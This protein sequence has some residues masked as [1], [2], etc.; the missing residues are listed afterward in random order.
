MSWYE[1]VGVVFV[2]ILVWVAC[3][4]AV[5]RYSQ[6]NQWGTADENLGTF[7]CTAIGPVVLPVLGVIALIRLAW[8]L[9]KAP[10][11]DP[12]VKSRW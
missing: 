5:Y 12:S 10:K 3:S 7:V 11:R 4:I 6:F 1:I 2:S 9:T 8:P